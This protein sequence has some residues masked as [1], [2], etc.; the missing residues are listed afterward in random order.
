PGAR[1]VPPT[2][3]N[4][5]T[6]SNGANANSIGNRAKRG[7]TYQR[8]ISEYATRLNVNWIPNSTIGSIIHPLL[9]GATKPASRATGSR[10]GGRDAELSHQRSHVENAPMLG[11]Q[12]V[13]RE[14]AYV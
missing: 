14:A 13:V 11:D 2:I 4:A 8:A 7:A 5:C 1:I 9:R 10:G 3:R 12:A 6:H